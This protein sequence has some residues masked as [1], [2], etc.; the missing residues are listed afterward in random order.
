MMTIDLINDLPAKSI[1]FTLAFPQATIPKEEVIYMR[2]PIGFFTDC[3][4]NKVYY[5]RLKKSL[6][7]LKQ[8][9]LNWFEHL[10]AGLERRRFK[11]SSIDPCIFYRRDAIILC[12]VDDCIIFSTRKSILDTIFQSLAHGP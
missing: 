4:D 3:P 10:K 5:L 9:G 11:Q 2:L 8:A 1:D 6:Y 12:Y 7:G